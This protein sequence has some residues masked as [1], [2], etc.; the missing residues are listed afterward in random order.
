[1]FTQNNYSIYFNKNQE[2]MAMCNKHM[3]WFIKSAICPR[4]LP[5]AVDKIF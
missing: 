1:M 4:T 3:H 5:S 2:L